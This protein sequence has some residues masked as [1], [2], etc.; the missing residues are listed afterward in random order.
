MC[1][2]AFT[3]V[4]RFVLIPQNIELFVIFPSKKWFEISLLTN[5]VSKWIRL[6]A[7]FSNLIIFYFW[8]KIKQTKTKI[9]IVWIMDKIYLLL[10]SCCHGLM[11]AA[12]NRLFLQA[13]NRKTPSPSQFVVSLL[14]GWWI[15]SSAKRYFFWA[16]VMLIFLLKRNKRIW[17]KE[18]EISPGFTP[19]VKLLCLR[20][21]S[22]VSHHSIKQQE[23]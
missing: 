9:I 5:I 11:L 21:S 1:D 23:I 8:Q 10:C 12:K 18:E 2:L 3:I 15:F 4:F 6:H 7:Y 13:Y 22:S 20:I 17:E 19:I 14:I 16:M